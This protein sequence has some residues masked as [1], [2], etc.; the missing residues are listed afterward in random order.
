MHTSNDDD[1]V[2]VNPE[3]NDVGKTAEKRSSGISPNDRIPM[4][5]AADC[6][7]SGLGRR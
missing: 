3:V 4:G 2:V 7:N 1:N 5:M 6:I